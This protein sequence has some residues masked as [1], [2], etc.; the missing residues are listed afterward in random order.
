MKT[1]FYGNIDTVR[2]VLEVLVKEEVE[3]G[4]WFSCCTRIDDSQVDLMAVTND[5]GEK[6]GSILA[7]VYADTV[8]R[9]AVYKF[10]LESYMCYM[11]IPSI[12][13]DFVN[14]SAYK[15]SYDKALATSNIGVIAEWLGIDY[16]VAC[17]KYSKHLDGVGIDDGSDDFPYVKLYETKSGERKVT[18]PRKMLDLGTK[19]TRVLPLFT[20]KIGVDT[21]FEYASNNMT[22]AMFIKDSGQ[23]RSIHFTFDASK[24][25]DIYGD[26]NYVKDGLLTQY[27]G[28]FLSNPNLGRGYIRVFEVGSSIYDNPTRS[29]NYARLV[30]F[31]EGSP[32]LSYINIDLSN[33]YEEFI[34]GIRCNPNKSV[35][36]VERLDLMG[37]GTSRTL[38]SRKMTTIS[39]LE[40]WASNQITLESTVFLRSLALFMLGSPD[41]FRSYDGKPITSTNSGQLPDDFELDLEM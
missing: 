1:D 33:V 11:E 37:V 3:K 22:E 16:D 18:K 6:L 40:T 29:I 32:D 41:W 20:L 23:K 31:S 38:N 12:K 13:K 9:S 8:Y 25:R 7:K 35:E 21:L 4:N 19:G 34:Q 5:D 36:I 2:K 24:I 30:S 17:S 15:P 26:T 39:E 14:S 28:D 10:L 27:D